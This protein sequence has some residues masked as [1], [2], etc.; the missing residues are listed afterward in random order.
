MTNKEAE[1]YFRD[2]C[3][4][5]KANNQIDFTAFA[6]RAGISAIQ[7]SS[8]VL[9]EKPAPPIEIPNLAPAMPAIKSPFEK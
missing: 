7:T 8:E 9:D 6:R 5:D 1:V 4:G 2:I 3:R